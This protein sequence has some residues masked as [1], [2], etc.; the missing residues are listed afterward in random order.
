MG[1]SRVAL[2]A[3]VTFAAACGDDN[4]SARTDAATTDDDGGGSNT[5]SGIDGSV[6]NVPCDYTEMADTTNGAAA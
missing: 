4:S 3:V 6:V 5:D 1:T 2:V